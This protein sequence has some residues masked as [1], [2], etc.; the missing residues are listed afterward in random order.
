VCG[1]RRAVASTSWDC[2]A[3]PLSKRMGVVLVE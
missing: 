3:P 1:T 2:P